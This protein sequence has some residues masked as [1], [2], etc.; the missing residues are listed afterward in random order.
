V[1]ICGKYI[2][3]ALNAC[4]VAALGFY[5][6]FLRPMPLNKYEAVIGLEVHTQLLTQSKLFCGDSA[7]YGGAPNT[8]ISPVTLAHPGTLPKM[9]R[10]VIEY[11]IKLGLALGCS[12]E[13]YNYFA[14]KNYFYPDLPKGYQV[15]QHT[16]PICKN[17]TVPITVNGVQRNILLNRIHMEEDAGKSIHDLDDN[18]TCVDL[19]RAGVALLEIVSEPDLHSGEEAYAYLTELRRLVRWLGV[20]DGNMEEGSMRCDANISIRLKGATELG[21]KVEVKN[22]NSIRNVKRAIEN[23]VQRLIDVTESGGTIVQETRGFDAD[24]GTSYSMRSKEAA[25]DYRY[26]PEPDL[27]PFVITDEL[28]AGIQSKL[29]VLP[30]ELEQKLMNELGLTAYDAAFICSDR[31]IADFFEAVIQHTRNSKAAANWLQ[32]PV[33]SYLNENNA[34]IKDFPVAP[35]GIA[36]LVQLVDDG[37][38]NFSTAASRIFNAMLTRPEAAPLDIANELN[39]VISSDSNAIEQWV[40][41]VL[42]K[43]P[44]KVLEYKKGKKGL[45]GLFTGEVKKLSKGKADIKAVNELL[46]AKLS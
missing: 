1:L 3:A 41:E 46:L 12:I 18:Y 7:A 16:T 40:D 4:M 8:H 45:I 19:N 33:K 10:Q 36:Q 13:Q 6:V 9:N 17:G 28:L 37:K 35:K 23:E 11:A 20:C 27:A 43:M 24:K 42:A 2:S 29:G 14:R 22:I 5:A 32:G 21:T 39:L 25:D 26:F 30:L 38:V 15:S 34:A 31:E 44:D